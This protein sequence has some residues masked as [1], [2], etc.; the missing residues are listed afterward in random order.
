MTY[1]VW[2]EILWRRL[3]DS[4][5]G[6]TGTSKQRQGVQTLVVWG[7]DELVKADRH[8]AAIGIRRDAILFLQPVVEENPGN[9]A[10]RQLYD[11]IR[12]IDLAS[13][14]G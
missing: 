3:S 10:L 4:V 14:S 13:S 11:T 9:Q 5:S 1:T 8:E 2:L 12:E 7:C 6:L